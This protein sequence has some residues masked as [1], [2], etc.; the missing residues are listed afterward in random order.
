MKLQVPLWA[1]V[2]AVLVMTVAGLWLRHKG[3]WEGVEFG[4]H[5]C[6]CDVQQAHTGKVSPTCEDVKDFGGKK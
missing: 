3:Y 2:L 6:D 5:R 1:A 4:Y